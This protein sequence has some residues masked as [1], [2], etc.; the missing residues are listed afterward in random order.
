MV[1]HLTSLLPARQGHRC[2]AREVRGYAARLRIVGALDLQA[3]CK[4]IEEN[5][6][7][8]QIA[9]SA[10]G[11]RRLILGLDQTMMRP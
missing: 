10:E 8:P 3:H 2:S 1:R 5:E 6:H 11:T 4:H 9:K 7:G